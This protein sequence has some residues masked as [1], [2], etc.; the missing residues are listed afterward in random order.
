MNWEK[1]FE[2]LWEKGGGGI[3]GKEACKA[4]Y[5]DG[6][7]KALEKILNLAKG[8]STIYS[9]IQYMEKELEK[10]KNEIS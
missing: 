8:K 1:D 10:L 7:I 6:Q 5:K 2:E 3:S 9:L 4:F